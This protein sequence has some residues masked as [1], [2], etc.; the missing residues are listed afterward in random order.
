MKC[1]RSCFGH[2]WA[3]QSRSSKK[4]NPLINLWQDLLS[5]PARAKRGFARS[6]VMFV[7]KG[8]VHEWGG[9]AVKADQTTS[10]WSVVPG[11]RDDETP[12]SAG[13]TERTGT[14]FKYNFYY[15]FINKVFFSILKW[16][17]RQ[18]KPVSCFMSNP[19][20]TD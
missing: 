6:R 2:S 1:Y 13:H 14:F 16:H 20:R 18:L 15:C 19:D 5:Q 4:L 17:L 12:S 3:K 8:S 10:A 9:S 7:N 11:Y